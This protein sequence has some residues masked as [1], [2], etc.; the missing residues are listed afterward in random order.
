MKKIF[1]FLLLICCMA[2]FSQSTTLVIS[3][4]YGAGGNSG[5]VLNADYVEIHNISATPQS[6]NGLSVQYESATPAGQWSGAAV[7]PNV[8]IPAGGY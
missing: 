7:L 8:S 2:G 4:V 3:Q 5:A 1:T 6:L